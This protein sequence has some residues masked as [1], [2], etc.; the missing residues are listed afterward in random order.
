MLQ[1]WISSRFVGKPSQSPDVQVAPEVGTS[2]ILKWVGLSRNVSA[3]AAS[4]RVEPPNGVRVRGDDCNLLCACAVIKAGKP[5]ERFASLPFL[6]IKA[7]STLAS[8]VEGRGDPESPEKVFLKVDAN[9]VEPLE[10]GPNL[11]PQDTYRGSGAR[12]LAALRLSVLG[13]PVFRLIEVLVVLIGL[14]LMSWK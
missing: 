1:R 13:L 2:Q 9:G 6:N 5:A 10:A 11:D 4:V 8:E 14:G 12:V 7:E 3:S